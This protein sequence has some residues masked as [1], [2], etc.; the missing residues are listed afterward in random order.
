MK[1]TYRYDQQT[2][3]FLHAEEAVIDPMESKVQNTEVYL[4]P[5]N[6]TFTPP[7]ESK[8]G[9]AVCWTGSKWVYK[10]DHRQKRD[11]GGM[12]IEGSGTPFW[13]PGDSWESPPRYMIELGALPQDAMTVRPQKPVEVAE[14]ERIQARIDELQ[15][16]L[17]ETD[18]YV[19]RYADTGVAIP[20]DVRADRQEARVEIETLREELEN[21]V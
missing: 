7:I 1:K 20:V 10:E 16:Y 18:W 11:T 9:Y 13:L 8:Q 3:E 21:F 19:I 4:L 2:K 12:V 14:R 5:A 15:T 17:V 6:S